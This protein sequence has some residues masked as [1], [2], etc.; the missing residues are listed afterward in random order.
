M[1]RQVW[2]KGSKS[3]QKES[4]S[5]FEPVMTYVIIDMTYVMFKYFSNLN[6]SNGGFHLIL[7]C[8]VAVRSVIPAVRALIAKELMEEQGLKQ[9][10]VAEILGISQSAVS[11]YSRK[12]RGHAI[13]VDDIEEIQP[14]IDGMVILLLDRTRQ[15]AE[16]LQLFCQACIA[17]RKT[18]LMCTFC[19]KSDP[20]INLEEC[21]FC[22]AVSEEAER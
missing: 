6:K 22:T 7:P 18:S 12:V 5:Q 8:E 21:R 15:S 3:L 19:Q 9:D 1:S 4:L 17:V 16:L 13:K 10:Q 20:K 14:F 2:K 11:K